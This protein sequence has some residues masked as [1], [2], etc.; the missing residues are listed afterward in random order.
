MKHIKRKKW[1]LRAKMGEELR[2]KKRKYVK[3]ERKKGEEK[4]DMEER[5]RNE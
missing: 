2:M 4:V 5:C 3:K 1:L